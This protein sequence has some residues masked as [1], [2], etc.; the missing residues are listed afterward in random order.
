[1]ADTPHC[2]FIVNPTAGRGRA[3]HLLPE[4]ETALKTFPHKNS[5]CVTTRAGEAVLLAREAAQKSSL[6]VA[7]G[8]D[9]TVNEVATGVCG[10]DAALGV[11]SV[12]SGNDFARTVNASH[13]IDQMLRRFLLPQIKKFDVGKVLL[14]HA[15]GKTEERYFFNSVG[16]GFD[17]AVAKK[18][19]DIRW[20]KG[21]PLYMSAL[22]HTLTGYKPHLLSVTSKQQRW[23]RNYFLLCFGIGRWEGGGFE[24][25][26]NAEPD[27]GKFQVCGITGNSIM[28]VLPVLPLVMTGKHGKKKCVELFDAQQMV[29]ESQQPFPVHGD[30]EFFG[31]NIRKVEITL[32]PAH[33]NVVTQS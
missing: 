33:L 6:V 18:V 10:T 5:L 4:L 28:K 16:L 21:I 24:L 2:T 25:T 3:K 9:G 26:P 31:M 29:V 27:D 14:T 11:I 8:G 12:G 32:L 7:V 1:M 15:D 22:L 17:A 30:G 19:S 20:L 23:A 13:N